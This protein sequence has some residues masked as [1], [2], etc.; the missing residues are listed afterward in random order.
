M[1]C[2]LIVIDQAITPTFYWLNGEII[3]LGF[4][5]NTQKGYRSLA[6]RELLANF[7]TILPASY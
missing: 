2:V 5:Q 3:Y 1:L 6:G 4:W 7:P